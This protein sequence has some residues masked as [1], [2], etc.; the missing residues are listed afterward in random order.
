LVPDWAL[1]YDRP[2]QD[3]ADRWE[4]EQKIIARMRAEARVVWSEELLARAGLGPPS[5]GAVV[6]KPGSMLEWVDIWP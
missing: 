4:W 6:A 1:R 3:L 2:P 5:P